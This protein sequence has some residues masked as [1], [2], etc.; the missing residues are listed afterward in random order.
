MVMSHAMTPVASD[1]TIS[2]D[3]YRLQLDTVHGWLHQTYWSPNIRRDVVERA[4]ANSYCAGAYLADGTQVAVARVVSDGATFGWLCDVFV[5]P[6]Y[7]GRGLA[8]QMTRE[9]MALPALAT[10]RSWMLGTRDAH[11]VYRA[12]G[13]HDMEPGRFMVLRPPTAHW[14]APS[15]SS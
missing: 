15:S 13:F 4:F 6:A 2:T 8:K 3:S 14:Q 11:E 10:L 12:L 1:V 9:L 5:A 7:R